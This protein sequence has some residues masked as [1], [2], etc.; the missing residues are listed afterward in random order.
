MRMEN[1]ER[2]TT[3]E[4]DTDKCGSKRNKRRDVL[5]NSSHEEKTPCC[6]SH[7][8]P[9]KRPVKRVSENFQNPFSFSEKRNQ[10]KSLQRK[11]E[12]QPKIAVDNTE[13]TVRTTH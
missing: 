4:T 9:K 13:H 6:A 7:K 10:K 11:Y 2:F 3:T 12:E 5:D 1:I 8:T